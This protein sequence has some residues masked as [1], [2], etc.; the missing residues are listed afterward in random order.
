L[1]VRR[2]ATPNYWAL[3][4]HPGIAHDSNSRSSY[5][6]RNWTSDERIV[7][8]RQVPANRTLDGC[9]SPPIPGSFGV[10][11]NGKR[12]SSSWHR[13]GDGANSSEPR[14]GLDRAACVGRWC[15]GRRR[16]GVALRRCGRPSILDGACARRSRQAQVGTKECQS[17]VEQR[18]R[19]WRRSDRKAFGQGMTPAFPT[20]SP[21]PGRWI[22]SDRI[23]P[24]RAQHHACVDWPASPHFDTIRWR[25][26]R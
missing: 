26:A 15:H 5:E 24:C 17:P 9:D 7:V 10:F 16:G 19:V 8:G 1:A 21:S 22:R 18:N 20:R 25:P 13:G 6:S 12:C 2:S 23:A 14:R 3:R 4:G 11:H